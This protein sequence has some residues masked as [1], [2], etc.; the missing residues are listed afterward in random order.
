MKKVIALI[1]SAAM[2]FSMVACGGAAS[3]GS[4]SESASTESTANSASGS[5]STASDKEIV[6]WS[7]WNDGEPQSEVI[8]QA[9][10]AYE[11]KTGVHVKIEWK[12]RDITQVLKASLDAG[13]KID[14]FDDDFQRVSQQF[15][16]NCLSLEDMAKAAG[17]EDFAVAALPAA[18][19]GWAGELV[20]IPYQPYTSGVFYTKSSFEK[21]NIT[22]EPKTWEEF[23]D[24]CQKLKDAGYTPLAQDDAYT[25][26]TFGFIL[27]RMVGEDGVK[28]LAMNGGW[29][30]SEQAK[31]AA[32][33]VVDLREKGYLSDT[34]P[35]AY[36][37]GENELGMGT[38]SMLVNASWVPGEI[39][40]NMKEGDVELDET[41]GMFNFPS[42]TAQDK[43]PSTVANIGAQ[44]MAVNKK[45]EHPQEAFDFIM[46]VTSG[47]FDQKMALECNGIPADT[48]NE[49][50]PEMIANV[51]D[52][53]NA[54]TDVYEWNMG[55]NA[56]ENLKE[57][58]NDVINKLFEGGL[59]AEGFV[60][61]MD[62]LYK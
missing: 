47:E 19:R 5:E 9:A 44:A 48:R 46:T 39:T 45:S 13:E 49:E 26:Y 43:D 29:A 18:V 59:D 40:N 28:E 21:A 11:E 36:P 35:D 23:M 2:A 24:V 56:N 33:F 17:Y 51:R 52:A 30:A 32:Q 50:W 54:Q 61:E 53:F 25:M 60:T 12:G 34:A 41:W 57:A 14:V 27:A 7:M 6:Y 38:A 22:A 15:V 8:K 3:S 37:N 62:A 16:D 55:L 1:L 20:A 58:I 10:A 31:Q 4:T 42:M